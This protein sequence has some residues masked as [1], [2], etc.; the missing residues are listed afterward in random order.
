MRVPGAD[1]VDQVQQAVCQ[2]AVSGSKVGGVGCAAEQ[3]GHRALHLVGAPGRPDV[4]ESILVCLAAAVLDIDLTHDGDPI[5][6]PAED[7]R[8]PILDCGIEAEAGVGGD[9][10]RAARKRLRQLQSGTRIVHRA[11]VDMGQIPGDRLQHGRQRAAGRRDVEP[12]EADRM[13]RSGIVGA[14]P[15]QGVAALG[16]LARIA[17]AARRDQRVEITVIAPDP[18]VNGPAGGSPE[19][20]RVDGESALL[21]QKTQHPIAHQPELAYLVGVLAQRDHSRVTDESAQRLQVVERGGKV[22]SG[23]TDGVARSPLGEGERAWQA[24]DRDTNNQYSCSSDLIQKFRDSSRL[25]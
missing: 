3:F 13:R 21:D 23:K 25:G 15:P 14:Q 19:L 20:H 9:Q 7:G 2:V 1:S 11:G 18:G 6:Q 24:H 5:E 10:T 22:G 8:E 4:R 12:G 17:V 16:G